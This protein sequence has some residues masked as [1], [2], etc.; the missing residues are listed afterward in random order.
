MRVWE[1]KTTFSLMD[2]GIAIPR[3]GPSLVNR[4]LF[5]EDFPA[6]DED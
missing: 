2:N 4:A 6:L 5:G 1:F 3:G